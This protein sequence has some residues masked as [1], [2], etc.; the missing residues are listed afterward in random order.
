MFETVSSTKYTCAY[1]VRENRQNAPKNLRASAYADHILGVHGN[2]W[3]DNPPSEITPQL[4]AYINDYIPKYLQEKRNKRKPRSKAEDDEEEEALRPKHS[5]ALPPPPCDDLGEEQSEAIP[6]VEYP[7]V[8]SDEVN[9]TWATVES[10]TARPEVHVALQ[11][12][13]SPSSDSITELRSPEIASQGPHSTTL[14]IA[15]GSHVPHSMDLDEPSPLAPRAD[16]FAAAQPVAP[17]ED[18]LVNMAV[19]A[20]VASSRASSVLRYSMDWES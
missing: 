12:I 5:I 15:G 11:T 18:P 4:L 19:F 3:S 17:Q 1:C 6:P 7:H 14:P 13:I 2:Y 8:S 20:W 9:Q 16:H 10:I